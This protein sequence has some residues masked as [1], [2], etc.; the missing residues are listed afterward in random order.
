MTDD[1]KARRNCRKKARYPTEARARIIGAVGGRVDLLWPYH[2][3]I[4]DHWHLT[5]KQQ[6]GT[7][8]IMPGQ[9]GIFR[10]G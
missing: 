7:P 6:H 3:K 5:R 8:P 2:C 10:C 4:C 1:K 9:S